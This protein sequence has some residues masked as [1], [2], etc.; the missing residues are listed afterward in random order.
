[1]SPTIPVL[2][3][4]RIRSSCSQKTSVAHAPTHDQA[5]AVSR[6]VAIRKRTISVI[7]QPIR[8]RDALGAYPLTT[9]E[10]SLSSHRVTQDSTEAIKHL[11]SPH[12]E[13]GS[14]SVVAEC[15]RLQVLQIDMG[16]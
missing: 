15:G 3:H 6:S 5:S 9:S 16:A 1:M 13:L 10:A 11:G 7:L 14:L 4:C 12:L 2:R 8:P